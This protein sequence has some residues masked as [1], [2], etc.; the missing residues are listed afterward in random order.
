MA[1]TQSKIQNRKSKIAGALILLAM[2]FAI[3]AL[4]AGLKSAATSAGAVKV[5]SNDSGGTIHFEDITQKAGINFTHYTG[6]FG[7]KYLPETMGPG[8][9]FIDYDNDGNP[10]I[11]LINGTDFPGHKIAAHDA[12][13][14]PQQRQRHLHRRYGQGGP[15][16]RDVRH[17]R[18]G[19]RLRQRRLGRHLHHR[20]R[21]GAPFPQRAQRNVQ[22]RHQDRGR[23]QHRLWR[24][25][26]LGGL[27]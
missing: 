22:G 6:A 10:D 3:V 2:G 26:R 27:R 4:M 17:G 21:R 14:L 13:A 20:P 23:E 25:R 19:G 18:G 12:E 15:G 5:P 9:A 8:C 11:L 24:Q 7:K 1:S 16:P